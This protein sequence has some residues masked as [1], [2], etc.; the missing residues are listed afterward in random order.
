MSPNSGLASYY[1]HRAEYR[2]LYLALL[3]LFTD[4]A[5][6]LFSWR[7]LNEWGMYTYI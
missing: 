5:I 6:W 7:C 4:S 1:G 2:S 3:T